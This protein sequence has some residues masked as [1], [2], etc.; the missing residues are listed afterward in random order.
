MFLEKNTTKLITKKTHTVTSLS[1]VNPVTINRQCPTRS[2]D[3]SA[4]T[5]Q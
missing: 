5:D 1:N 3:V 2:P 4:F